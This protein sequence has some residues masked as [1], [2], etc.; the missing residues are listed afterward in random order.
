MD[1]QELWNRL[2]RELVTFRVEKVTSIDP[3]IL[4]RFMTFLE[5]VEKI[6]DEQEG[7]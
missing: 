1:Y 7:G 2:R 6:R 5:E 4:L 3:N